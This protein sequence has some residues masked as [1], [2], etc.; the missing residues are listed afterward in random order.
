MNKKDQSFSQQLEDEGFEPMPDTA[1][2]FVD[3]PLKGAPPGAGLSGLVLEVFKSEHGQACTLEVRRKS[4][5]ANARAEE[6]S[7]L[8][9]KIQFFPGGMLSVCPSIWI[10]LVISM[11][12]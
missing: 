10:G 4:R 12:A 1:I 8:V 6:S 2:P 3:W 7:Q 11:R 5:T 9:L